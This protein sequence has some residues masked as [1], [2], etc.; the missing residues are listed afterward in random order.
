MANH[1]LLPKQKRIFAI[2][3][4]LK[5]TL[6]R[7]IGQRHH[8]YPLLAKTTAIL[9]SSNT[10]V[11]VRKA[12]A[13]MGLCLNKDSSPV[14]DLEPGRAS[15][16]EFINKM[17]HLSVVMFLF[18]NLQW[19]MK[20]RNV[21]YHQSVTMLYK[22][23][24]YGFLP[25]HSAFSVGL[26]VSSS[27]NAFIYPSLLFIHAPHLIVTR[28]VCGVTLL[29]QMLLNLGTKLIQGGI[30]RDSCW[31]L[32]PC[33]SDGGRGG[34]GGSGSCGSSSSSSSSGYGSRRHTRTR[35]LLFIPFVVASMVN[36][37]W[38]CCC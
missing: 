7:G 5:N 12:L 13:D 18:D 17:S 25:Y 31:L 21:G 10:K 35:F 26:V 20:A 8:D 14:L 29:A 30:H 4:I 37:D 2:A 36:H 6:S 19:K 16:G 1:E 22:L 28:I 27:A 11:W 34:G 33:S 24:L 32:H 3:S 9:A 15:E 23:F 38:C